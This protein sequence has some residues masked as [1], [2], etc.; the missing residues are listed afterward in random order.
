MMADARNKKRSSGE[1]EAIEAMHAVP[2]G[3]WT[4]GMQCVAEYYQQIAKLLQLAPIEIVIPDHG[5]A[6]GGRE[7]TKEA[8]KPME[9]FRDESGTSPRFVLALNRRL[10]GGA[11]F[12]DFPTNEKELLT[13]F[14]REAHAWIKP[15]VIVA[16]VRFTM[17]KAGGV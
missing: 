5:A 13:A 9:F 3:Q 2:T 8:G 12:D 10:L 17:R 14:V 16:F 11:F 7:E 4:E 1:P 6:G 15:E